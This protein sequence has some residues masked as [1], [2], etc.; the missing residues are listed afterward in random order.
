MGV[1]SAA[2]GVEVAAG[3]ITGVPLKVTLCE[4]LPPELASKLR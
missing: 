4:N 3:R 1:L 2:V